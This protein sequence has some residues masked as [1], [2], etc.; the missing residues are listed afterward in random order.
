MRAKRRIIKRCNLQE[1]KT[2]RRKEIKKVRNNSVKM[3]P[4]YMFE[5]GPAIDSIH[6]EAGRK[7]SARINLVKLKAVREF[8]ETCHVFGDSIDVLKCLCDVNPEEL[9]W[10]EFYRYTQVHYAIAA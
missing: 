2:S 4:L 10:F 9:F 6:I 8:L 5:R 1:E 3:L 7:R